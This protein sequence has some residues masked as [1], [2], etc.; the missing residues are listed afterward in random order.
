MGPSLK[1][2]VK[3][4]SSVSFSDAPPD[5]APAASPPPPGLGISPATSAS[6]KLKFSGFKRPPSVSLP[7][8]AS[9]P[10]LKRTKV[11]RTTKPSKK[12]LESQNADDDDDGE[13]DEELPH[14]IVSRKPL[15]KARK[16]QTI[17]KLR[18]SSEGGLTRLHSIPGS[19]TLAS[20]NLKNLKGVKLKTKGRPP[21]RPWGE[22]YDSEASDKEEDPAIEE[23]LI[24][25]LPPGDDADYVRNAITNK[26]LGVPLEQGGADICL[27]FFHEEGRRAA[28]RVRQNIYAATV[29][30]LPCIIEGM[31]SWDKR[32]W[33][34][35]ADI[36]QM[37]LAYAKV[38]NL[39]EAKTH[40][41][42]PEVD[43]T[44]FQYPHGITPP[45][46]YARRR[47]FRKRL[48]AKDIEA[49]EDAVEKL[50]EA[51][52]KAQTVSAMVVDYDDALA[53]QSQVDHDNEAQQDEQDEDLDE[54][55]EGEDD[56]YGDMD[57][58]GDLD[59]T[60]EQDAEGYE[61][62]FD[63]D[64]AALA[65]ELEGA[66]FEDDGVD[67]LSGLVATPSQTAETPQAIETEAEAPDDNDQE[68]EDDSGD[69]SEDD[70]DGAG[71]DDA[72]EQDP[73]ELARIQMVKDDIADLE[74]KVR[75][76][77]SKLVPGIYP[78][79]RQK[80]DELVRKYKQEIQLKK[81]AIGLMDDD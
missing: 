35:A 41:L 26:K 59:D 63:E 47:R 50:I 14:T 13:S 2:T 54:D 1:L 77:Q 25:R 24:L 66:L 67:D 81:A 43:S 49:I 5:I 34:K 64:E 11:G 23:E 51:D 21:R 70:E 65:A 8:E 80:V 16:S 12:A 42:P 74:A 75:H 39:E 15:L 69:D 48:R 52:R 68:E 44:T 30:D 40:P 7:P 60:M 27:H 32:G 37:L 58:E 56:L 46:H 28:V 22:G 17:L 4:K 33:W 20:A 19:T 10:K 36:A 61:D 78:I 76:E 29:V 62:P 45:L 9:P 72:A 18:T 38:N 71:D 53:E 57:G 79:I 6:L 55:A 73:V 3:P 31:K